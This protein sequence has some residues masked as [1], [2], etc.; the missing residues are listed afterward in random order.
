MTAILAEVW[1]NEPDKLARIKLILGNIKNFRCSSYPGCIGVMYNKNNGQ[2]GLIHYHPRQV[3]SPPAGSRLYITGR[4][5]STDHIQIVSPPPPKLGAASTSQANL[6]MVTNAVFVGAMITIG[7]V[8][9]R[10]HH[11][12]FR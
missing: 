2:C 10:L 5:I 4:Y 11:S 9:L 6:A 8:H 7:M 12:C 1:A 3:V